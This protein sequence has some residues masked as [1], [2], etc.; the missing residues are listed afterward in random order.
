MPSIVDRQLG[1]SACALGNKIYVVGG[2]NPSQIECLDAAQ[3]TKGIY[4]AK[5]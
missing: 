2:I 4:A 3:D 1:H 5:W